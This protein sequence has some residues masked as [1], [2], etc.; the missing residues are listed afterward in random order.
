MR[1]DV[2]ARAAFGIP[3]TLGADVRRSERAVPAGHPRIEA[4]SIP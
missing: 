1:A 2:S 3:D 4:K